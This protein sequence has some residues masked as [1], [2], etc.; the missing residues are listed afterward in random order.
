MDNETWAGTTPFHSLIPTDFKA[1]LGID[2]RED[3]LAG[4]ALSRL[5]IP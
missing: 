4:T 2:E 3:V 5:P 1:I